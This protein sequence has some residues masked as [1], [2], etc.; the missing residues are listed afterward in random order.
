MDLT[1]NR[2]EYEITDEFLRAAFAK[3]DECYGFLDGSV[4]AS[5]GWYA[6]TPTAIDIPALK[7]HFDP[8][9]IYMYKGYTHVKYRGQ[10]LHAIAMGRALE[11]YKGKGFRGLLSYV[12]WNNFSSLKS[13]YRLGY[14][15]IGNIYLF[16][17]FGRYRTHADRS[18]LRYGL[19]LSQAAELPEPRE[20][21]SPVRAS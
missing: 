14:S 1:R 5:Y 6:N 3:G 13:C 20:S 15:D 9:Y 10:R 11:A 7:L 17:L 8:R 18:C 19:H 2:P 16:Q 12:E 21:P 4:L